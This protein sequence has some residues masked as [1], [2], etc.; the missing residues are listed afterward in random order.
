MLPAPLT[1]QGL[2]R[3]AR[4]AVAPR[5]LHRVPAEEEV[6]RPVHVAGAEA[7]RVRPPQDGNGRGLPTGQPA[8]APPAL[9][10]VIGAELLDKDFFRADAPNSAATV[11]ARPGRLS[12]P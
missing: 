10:Q 5:P 12:V 8:R 1:E 7:V 2:P 11:W 4:L 6:E 9:V 3:A